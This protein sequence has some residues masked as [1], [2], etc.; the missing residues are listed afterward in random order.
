MSADED[1]KD[2]IRR[3]LPDYWQ[4]FA[5]LEP[6]VHDAVHDAVHDDQDTDP[7]EEPTHERRND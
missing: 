1:R 5:E 2:R 7:E 3:L 4:A 6:D